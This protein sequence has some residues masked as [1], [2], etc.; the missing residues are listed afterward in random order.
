VGSV[1]RVRFGMKSGCNGFFHLLPL[2]GGRFRSALCGEVQLSEGDAAPLL[3]SL[4]EAR[5]PLLAAPARVLFRPAADTATARA[6]VARGESLGVHRR[7]TCAG[8]SPWWLVS[9]GRAPAPVLYPAKVGARAF[10]FLNEEGLVEDKKWHALF[11]EGIAPDLLAAA[12][13]AT[14]VRLAVDE[15]AR[16]LTGA[17]AIADVDCRVLAAAPFPRPEALAAAAGAVRDAFAALARDRV[18]TDL[19]AMLARPAQRALDE[20]VGG[21]LGLP[22]REVERGRRAL[23]VRLAERL[24]RA[25]EIRGRMGRT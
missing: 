18:S 24:E 12:L 17:Q 7:A 1:A 3:A 11:P 10:A 22:A 5:A 13:S 6:H 25:A 15:G 2:G 9:P 4:K 23:L 16:Q 20:A 21:A 8:R 14:P 19:A